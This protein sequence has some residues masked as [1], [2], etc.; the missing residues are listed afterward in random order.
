MTEF[1]SAVPKIRAFIVGEMEIAEFMLHFNATEEIVQY[2]ERVIE[3]IEINHLPIKRR[4]I[5]KNLCSYCQQKKQD[6]KKQLPD[7]IFEIRRC[8]WFD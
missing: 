4:T 5:C 1:G 8:L 7:G 3:Q 2:L 6:Y